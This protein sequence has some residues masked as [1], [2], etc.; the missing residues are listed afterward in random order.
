MR[1]DI[2]HLVSEHRECDELLHRAEQAISEGQLTEALVL[3]NRFSIMLNRHLLEEEQDWFPAFEKQTGMTSGPTMVMR[4]E[5][6]DIRDMAA[7]ASSA[8]NAGQTEE[9]LAAIDTLNVLLQQHN[10]KEENILY[11]MLE[12]VLGAKAEGSACCGGCTCSG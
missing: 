8:A 11:P 4:T 3:L 1:T 5:H 6:A 2:P 10:V 12:R 7:Q 9:A